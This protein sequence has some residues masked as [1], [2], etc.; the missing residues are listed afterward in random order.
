MLRFDEI[1]WLRGTADDARLGAAL[2][3]SWMVELD[4]DSR[5]ALL[6]PPGAGIDRD[7]EVP[8]DASLSFSYGLDPAVNRPVRF[9]VS[10]AQSSGTPTT[11][12]SHTLDP[13]RGQSNRWFTA[14]V[15]LGAYSGSPV[16]LK[17]ATTGDTDLHPARAMSVWSNIEILTDQGSE[18]PPNVVVIL[19]DTLRAD[20]LSSYG[21][22]RPTSPNIDRWAEKSAVLFENV[23]APSPWTLPSHVSLFSGL[24]ALRHGVNHNLAA[25]HDLTMMAEMM[26]DHG[27]TTA[28]ITGGGY[29]RPAFGL[30]Q[31]FD[32]FRFWPQRDRQGELADGVERALTWLD[33]HRDRRFLLFFHTY[34]IHGPH[35]RSEPS[36]SRIMGEEADRLPRMEVQL[37]AHDWEGPRSRGDYFVA[38]DPRTKLETAD[39]TDAE[40]RLVRGM[41]DSA[42]ADADDQV[43]RILDSLDRLGLRDTTLVIL[44]SDHGEALGEEDRAGH[45]YL[46][47]YN[48]MIPLIVEFPQG[49]KGGTRIAEQVRLVDVL[50]TILDAVGKPAADPLDGVSLLPLIRGE[51]SRVP[52]EA[53]T[54]ASS[55]N[56]GLGLRLENRLKY[57]FNNS[58]WSTMVG[59]EELYDLVSDPAEETNSAMDDLVTLALRERTR[60]AI[61]NQHQGLR[62]EIRNPGHGTLDGVFRGDWSKR[63]SVKSVDSQCRCL[64]WRDGL[65]A[66]FSLSAGQR[67]TL[68]FEGLS[69]SRAVVSG[70]FSGRD[71]GSRQDFEESFELGT[72]GHGVGL[73]L[74]DRGWQRV[75][76]EESV[77]TGFWLWS[78]G[79]GVRNDTTVDQNPELFDQL[80]ALGYVE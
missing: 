39:L 15:P 49:W 53:W 33:D 11:V 65:G 10:I 70:S 27:Y 52:K 69:G 26:H 46:N 37:R 17:L 71:G 44:T 25:T 61:L 63:I 54:Y 35:R 16:E 48:V 40:K 73:A 21:H 2:E 78:A 68:L 20:H 34:H 38:I 13:Q 6:C 19:L 74:T 14:T 32:S 31:G 58:A 30:A 4:S 5:L 41:Y 18:A 60:E 64:T 50:P 79:V 42:I 3:T 66:A 45:H 7:L 24:N 8:A 28:A 57:V 67:T 9:T 36:F 62:V 51:P 29:L 22:Q 72:L 59:D 43:R 77:E 75:E 23:V 1:R 56:R 47:E 80:R 55:D 76:V 12:F